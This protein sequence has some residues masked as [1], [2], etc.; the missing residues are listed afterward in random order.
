MKM[1]IRIRVYWGTLKSKKRRTR[2]EKKGTIGLDERALKINKR[3][4]RK[5]KEGRGGEIKRGKGSLASL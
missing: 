4:R 2:V 5:I 3:K 1:K